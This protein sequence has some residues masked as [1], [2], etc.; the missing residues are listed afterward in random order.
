MHRHLWINSRIQ[1]FCFKVEMHCQPQ[2]LK[3]LFLNSWNSYL[4]YLNIPY[5]FMSPQVHQWVTQCV[6]IVQ[7]VIS[8][9]AT[10]PLS[11][12]SPTK[13]AQTWAWRHSDGAH[14]P[15]T[16]SAPLRI[17]QQHWSALNITLYAT[18]V[19][20]CKLWH[21]VKSLMGIVRQ[22]LQHGTSGGQKPS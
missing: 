14:P 2:K 21:G 9:P 7:L 22:L 1:G 11:H 20:Q 19:R 5:V 16:A 17:R 18:M 12:V 13:T 3:I 15:L 10:P 4:T 6:N 8:L